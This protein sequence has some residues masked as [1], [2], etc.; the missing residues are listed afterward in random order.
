MNVMRALAAAALLAGSLI[1][2]AGSAQADDPEVPG[3][4]QGVYTA[5]VAGQGTTEWT[6]FPSCVPT[7]GDLREPLYLP[8]ACRLHVT[9]GGRQGADA[10][11]VGG[12][13]T[14]QYTTADGLKCADGSTAAQQEIYSFDGN[15]LAGTLKVLHGAACGGP[16]AMDKIPFTLAFK[17]PLPLP[18]DRYPLYCEPGGLRRCF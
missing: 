8:V 9:P 11:Q 6:I 2:A 3:V 7:V 15:T 17:Q 1:G 5:D 16:A 12:L 10:V 13:W 18:V 14:F 4:L